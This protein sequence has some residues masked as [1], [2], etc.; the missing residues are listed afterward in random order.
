[1]ATLTPAIFS[2]PIASRTAPSTNA[3][4]LACSTGSWV[5]VTAS[6]APSAIAKANESSD[7][8][9]ATSLQLQRHYARRVST[10]GAF[11]CED[12]RG[13]RQGDRAR[14]SLKRK[15]PRR[16]LLK[17]RTTIYC[18]KS[19]IEV[20]LPHEQFLRLRMPKPQ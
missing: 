2:A 12:Q 14:L 8:N 19:E 16:I 11:S 5:C 6:I 17:A 3:S 18:R 7:R 9:M 13:E 10:L 20:S 15:S 4:I 1:M